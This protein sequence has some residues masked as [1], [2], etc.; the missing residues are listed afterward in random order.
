MRDLLRSQCF[1]LWPHL[2]HLPIEP[3]AFGWDNQLFRLGDFLSIRLPRRKVAAALIET[4]QTWLPLLTS[5]L[6]IA[7]PTPLYCGKSSEKYPWCWS[8]LPWIKGVCCRHRT[9]D[10]RRRQ[11]VCRILEQSPPTGPRL[12]P[13]QSIPQRL[14]HLTRRQNQPLNTAAKRDDRFNHT[15]NQKPRKQGSL[16]RF[17]AQSEQVEAKMDS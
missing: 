12:Y 10:S 7:I 16:C 15:C 17:P 8:V 1:H 6:P 11:T 5:Q 14:A 13:F 4:E 2:C 9:A 3:V